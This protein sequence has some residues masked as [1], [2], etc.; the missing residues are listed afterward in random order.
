[1]VDLFRLP[2]GEYS[3]NG[4]TIPGVTRVLGLLRPYSRIPREALALAQ[5]R[6]QAAHLAI[7]LIEGGGDGSGLNR[8]SVHPA[9][10][11]HV[12]AWEQFKASAQWVTVATEVPV[13]SVVYGFACTPDLYGTLRGIPSVIDCK[14]GMAPL[15]ALQLAAQAQAIKETR[16]LKI[17]PRQYSLLLR[18]TGPKLVEHTAGEDFP[19]FASLLQLYGWLAKNQPRM[20]PEEIEPDYSNFEDDIAQVIGGTDGA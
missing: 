8:A 3:H 20:L 12:E 17:K 2:S 6:G 18:P 15:V 10:L 5:Q 11:P 1:M 19:T 14:C 13:A 4:R 9:V 7:H 16:R